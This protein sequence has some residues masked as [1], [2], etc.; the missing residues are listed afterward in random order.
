M[1]GLGL[2]VVGNTHDAGFKACG[3]G[4]VR[5]MGIYYIGIIQGIIF[6]TPYYP[7]VRFGCH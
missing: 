5:I 3:L 4:L 7:P 6:L 1:W 2:R